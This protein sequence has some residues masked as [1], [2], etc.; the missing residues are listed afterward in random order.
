MIREPP[1]TWEG[2]KGKAQTKIKR[3]KQQRL[4]KV[5]GI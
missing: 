3:Q 5:Q 1:N 2:Y 4:T